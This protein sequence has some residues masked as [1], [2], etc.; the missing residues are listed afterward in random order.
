MVGPLLQPGYFWG[1]HDA[2]HSVYFLQQFNVA[3]QD[4]VWYPRWAP[5]FAF[6]YGY[7][8]FNIYGPLSSYAGSAFHWLGLDIVTAVKV[9]FGLSAV[10]SGLTMYSFARRLLGPPGALIAALTY[11]YIPYHLFDL[12]VRAALAESVGFIFVPLTLWGF[13][14]VMVKPRLQAVLL[15]GLAYAGLMFTSNLLALIFTPI[16]GLYVAYMMGWKLLEAMS[17][18]PDKSLRARLLEIR[19]LALLFHL[20]LP[21]ALALAAGLGLTAIFWLPA[22]LEYRFVRVDQWIGGRFAFGDD[23]VEIFQLFSPKW[24][25]GSSIPGP[26]DDTGFQIGLVATIL[27]ILSFLIVPKVQQAVIRRTLFFFQGMTLAVL[28][29]TVPISSFVWTVLPLS[30]F[31]QFPWRLLVVVAPFISICG[32]HHYDRSDSEK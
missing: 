28:F 22:F 6:G 16:L 15:T 9:L 2:R 21:P 31:A 23:F 14:E 11:V 1:A 10:L 20:G 4:G 17:R 7:P 27:F 5:D 12:Y 26:G 13:Y 29:L 19:P 3:L 8:F 25:F 18:Q 24:G 30:S 32:R